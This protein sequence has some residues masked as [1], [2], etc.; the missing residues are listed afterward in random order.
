MSQ[1]TTERPA[2]KRPTSALGRAADWADERYTASS[3]V[4]NSLNKVFP[5]NWSFMM[6]EIA[7]YSFIILLLTGT[8]LAFFF[9]PSMADTVYHGTYKPLSGISMSRAYASTLDITFDVRGGLV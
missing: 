2:G 9:D 3:F 5:D 6:G 4:R 8:Y 1:T 7:L